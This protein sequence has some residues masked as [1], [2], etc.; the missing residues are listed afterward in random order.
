[1]SGTLSTLSKE[2][3]TTLEFPVEV[4]QNLGKMIPQMLPFDARM[5]PVMAQLL[6]NPS[7]MM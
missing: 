1:V 2:M 7:F 3:L 4:P 6:K 5:R